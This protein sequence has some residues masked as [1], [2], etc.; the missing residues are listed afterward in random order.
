M[1]GAGLIELGEYT[2]KLR[3]YNDGDDLFSPVAEDQL[4]ISDENVY[5][6]LADIL[7]D[8]PVY[9]KSATII[10]TAVDL[11]NLDRRSS[12]PVIVLLSPG[13]KA[14]AM[15]S[16]ELILRTAF[17]LG[18]ARD[19]AFIALGGGVITDIGAF[20]SSL[21]MRGNR[22]VLIPS[23]LL[24]MVDASFGGK[25]GINYCGY[26]NMVGTFY[27]AGELRIYPGLL[28][29]LPMKEVKCGLA[30][31]IKSAMLGDRELYAVLENRR[32]EIL[33]QTGRGTS[34]LMTELIRRSLMVKTRVVTKDLRE[35]GTRAHLN[36]GHSFAHALESVSGAGWSHGEAV[37]WG[38]QRALEAGVLLGVTDSEYARRSEKLLCAYAYQIDSSGCAASDLISAM[39]MDKKKRGG[40]L[41]FVLQSRLCTTFQQAMGD[42]IL[43][44]ILN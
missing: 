16:V 41:R 43:L 33:P 34:Q 42:D 2:T 8:A 23:S 11:D 35:A 24:A 31:V 32:Q 9:S 38:I 27:P 4:Y 39:K 22:C 1:D 17:A 13:E 7:P 5:K 18:Y 28:A 40:E 26:K 15:E 20:A 10:R 29:S 25:T 6:A 37:A 21:F 44:K 14:K 12:G 30:E 19:S 36:L 3:F